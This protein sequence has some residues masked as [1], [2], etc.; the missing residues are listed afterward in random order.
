MTHNRD[1][2]PEQRATTSHSLSSSTTSAGPDLTTDGF[3]AAAATPEYAKLRRAFRSFAVPMTIAGLA[4]YFVYV[5]ASIYAPDAM[6]T[7]LIGALNVGMALGLFQF[8]VTYVWTAL[9]VRYATR[10]LDPIAADLKA[11]LMGEELA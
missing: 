4:S 2:E 6:A 3:A 11:R 5:I 10:R 9:Y 1:Q 7:P 8:L